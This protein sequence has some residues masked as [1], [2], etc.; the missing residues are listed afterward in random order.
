MVELHG[1]SEGYRFEIEVGRGGDGGGGGGG[2]E[3]GD[4]G[5]RGVDGSVVFVPLFAEKGGD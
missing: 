1:L 2:Y 4:A 3:Q 5:V